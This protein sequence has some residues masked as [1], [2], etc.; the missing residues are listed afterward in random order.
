MT[1]AE[2]ESLA[3]SVL[4]QVME[5]KITDENVEVAVITT[6]EKKFTIYSKDKVQSILSKLT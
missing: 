3:L 2:A 1:L 6:K 5:E 4:K